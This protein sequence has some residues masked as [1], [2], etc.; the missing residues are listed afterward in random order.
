MIGMDFHEFVVPLTLSFI[1]SMAAHYL[2]STV[3]SKVSMAS[4]QSVW[5]SGSGLG[6]NSHTGPVVVSSS[7]DS[8]IPSALGAF[9]DAAT[10]RAQVRTMPVKTA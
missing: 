7:G 1:D 3:T 2:Y 9:A 6:S 5:R 4:Y 10:W 8:L